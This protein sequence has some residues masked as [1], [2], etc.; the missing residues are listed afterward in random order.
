M[1]IV[2]VT[3]GRSGAEVASWVAVADRWWRRAIGLLG[4]TALDD[5]EGILLAPCRSVHTLGMRFPIDVA[6]LDAHGLVV[7]TSPALSPGRMARGGQG[8]RATLELPSGT[9]ATT[10]TRP[11]DR[12]IFE[13]EVL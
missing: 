9:L 5:G 4:R 7:S 13:E 10:S 6:F 3:N 11:G 1:R 8:A 12:L 2:R